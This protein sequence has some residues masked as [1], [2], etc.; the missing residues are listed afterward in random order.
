MAVPLED[1]M[2][3]QVKRR[4]G[5]K[6][7]ERK[8]GR[9]DVNRRNTALYGDNLV[10]ICFHNTQ[11]GRSPIQISPCIHW[12]S[13]G[14]TFLSSPHACKLKHLLGKVGSPLV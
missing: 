10:S 4:K 6:K 13:H 5:K 12:T 3:N 8:W 1:L 7:G 2:E 11:K 9:W 14:L